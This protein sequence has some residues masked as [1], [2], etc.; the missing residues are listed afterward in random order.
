MILTQG[1]TGY[2]NSEYTDLQHCSPADWT[3]ILQNQH[4]LLRNQKYRT[5][6]QVPAL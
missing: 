3:V 1:I 2:L 5:S 4:N 6:E